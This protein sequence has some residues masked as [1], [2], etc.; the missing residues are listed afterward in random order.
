MRELFMCQARGA[1]R[2]VKSQ[3]YDYT[4]VIHES[5]LLFS[6]LNEI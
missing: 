4:D 3:R 5:E 1:T 6:N 2:K